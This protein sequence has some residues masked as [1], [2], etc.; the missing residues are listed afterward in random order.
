MNCDLSDSKKSNNV[1]DLAVSGDPEALN[2]LFAPCMTRL[3]RT[4]ARLLRNPQDSEDAVQ[5]GMLSAFRHLDQFQGR[6]QFTTWMHT[7]VANAAKTKLRNQQNRVFFLSL[8]DAL[9]E[10]DYPL[11]DMLPDTHATPDEDYAR[12]ERSQLLAE[13]LD[14]LPPKLRV[15]VVLCDIEGLR[16]KEAAA[17]LGITASAVKTRRFRA[18]RLL[19]KMAR[20][21]EIR[22][23]AVKPDANQVCAIP[24]RRPRLHRKPRFSDLV[25]RERHRAASRFVCP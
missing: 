10:H 9:P 14:E 21:S 4:A 13:I 11:A 5:D 7:I 15:I 24:P 17:R 3:K 23:L 8:D 1:L 19:L 20:R 18:N 16:L 22:S 2:R 25:F 12:N 6:S